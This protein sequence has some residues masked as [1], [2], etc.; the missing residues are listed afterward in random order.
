MNAIS[1]LWSAIKRHSESFFQGWMVLQQ[2]CLL[3]S[4]V[5]ELAKWMFVQLICH[6]LLPSSTP[7]WL[8][9]VFSCVR[10]CWNLDKEW[11]PHPVEFN[12]NFTIDLSCTKVWYRISKVLYKNKKID[13]LPSV[14]KTALYGHSVRLVNKVEKTQITRATSAEVSVSE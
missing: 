6:L 8:Q 7:T 12:G 10:R 4:M 9:I 2:E 11:N 1:H 14:G 13:Q 3:V 5:D